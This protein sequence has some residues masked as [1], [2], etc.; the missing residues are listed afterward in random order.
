MAAPCFAAS[1]PS[2]MKRLVIS[3]DPAPSLA[4]GTTNKA[5]DG[6][7]SQNVSSQSNTQNNQV[8]FPVLPLEAEPDIQPELIPLVANRTLT[9]SPLQITHAI[10]AIHDYDRDATRT[11]AEMMKLAGSGGQDTLVLVPEFLIDA[12]IARM[13]SQLPQKGSEFARWPLG[14][15]TQGADSLP[16]GQRK[17][18]SSFT[19]IDLLLLYLSDKEIFPNL[20]QIIL[21]GHGE[22]GDFIQ[23][24]AA[25]GRAPDI[26]AKQNLTLRYLVA[27]PT[28]Y[29]YLTSNRYIDK[30]GLVV[31]DYQQ[32]QDYDNWPYGLNVLPPY[33]KKVG[34]NTIKLRFG[35][36]PIV[37]MIGGDITRDPAPDASCA[38]RLQGIDRMA[39]QAIYKTYLG[40]TFGEDI[41]KFQRFFVIPKVGYDAGALYGSLCGAITLFGDGNC[42]NI[43][44]DP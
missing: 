12:D 30:K 14:A 13:G 25:V 21:V 33:V 1:Q 20:E 23:R 38:A 5:S 9:E 8:Y 39:R 32:C 18:I 44:P 7:K 16:L 40:V 28:S 26:L 2:I 10:L 34:N 3:E 35:S 43:V 31:P 22:G 29:L 19:I 17:G 42:T 15:W 41:Y 4:Q 11:L 6:E 24:Y 27:N 36:L 37:Y